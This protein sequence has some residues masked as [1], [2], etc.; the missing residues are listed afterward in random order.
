M[1]DR[2]LSQ[3][4]LQNRLDQAQELM[5]KLRDG[6]DGIRSVVSDTGYVCLFVTAR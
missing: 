3:D 4:D 5:S 1:K 2:T 6:T